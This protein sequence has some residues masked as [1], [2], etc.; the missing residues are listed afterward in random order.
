MS[1]S[2]L[3]SDFAGVQLCNLV[4]SLIFK[5]LLVLLFCDIVHQILM[6]GGWPEK[7]SDCPAFLHAFWNYRDELTVADGLILKGTR[8]IIPKSLQPD[9]LR[10]LHFAHQGAEKCWCSDV[11]GKHQ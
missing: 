4:C 10:R 1:C 2:V 3:T 11:L 8:I 6:V 5:V 9:I 7:G